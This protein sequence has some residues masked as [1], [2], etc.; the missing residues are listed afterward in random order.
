MSNK[1][2]LNESQIRQFMKL[3][4]LEPLTP[5]FVEGLAE[6][7]GRGREEGAAGYGHPDNNSRL[8]EADEEAK[9]DATEDEL[10]DMDAEADREGDEIDDLEDELDAADDADA[11]EGRMISV[12]DFLAALEGALESAMGEEVEISDES[13]DED[14]VE[15]DVEMDAEMDM[16]GE[17]VDVD[18]D[19]EEMLQEKAYTAKKEKPGADKRKGAEKRG[20]E[21]TLAKTKGHGRVDYVNEE[22]GSKK[23]EYRRKDKDGKVGHRA[24]EGKDGHYKDYEGPAGGNKGDESKTDPGHKDYMKESAATDE[25]VEQITKRVAARILKSALKKKADVNENM[26]GDL[27]RMAKKGFKR[28]TGVSAKDHLLSTWQD[29]VL[30]KLKEIGELVSSQGGFTGTQLQ[31]AKKEYMDSARDLGA[32]AGTQDPKKEAVNIADILLQDAGDTA[33]R[34]ALHRNYAKDLD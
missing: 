24:G 17:D 13:G 11:A 10:G 20:A 31:Q 33:G 34:R 7:H 19:A 2:L 32:R 26:L 21:G 9:L 8:E 25:L 3:A 23:G 4:K 5:G 15:A 14:E 18:M 6:S 12:D 22:E 27:G 1:N 28:A 30:P 16:D 29:G